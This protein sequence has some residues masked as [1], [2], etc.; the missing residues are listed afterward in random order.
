MRQV[1]EL[2]REGYEVS[3]SGDRVQVKRKIG[4]VPD[5]GRVRVLL[6]EIRERK[7]EAVRYLMRCRCSVWCD[8]RQPQRWVSY[9]VCVYHIEMNDPVCQGCRPEAKRRKEN[10]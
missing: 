10:P 6:Q 4:F 9:V 1:I 2:E 8:R 5:V 7:P 3:L